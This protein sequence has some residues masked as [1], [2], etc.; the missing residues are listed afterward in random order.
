MAYVPSKIQQ[1]IEN[2]YEFRF[3]DYISRGFD[4]MNRNTGLFIGYFLVYIL[5]TV[6]LAAIPILGSLATV[7]IAPALSI[8]IMI[9]AH[10]T[11]IGESLQFNDFF[12][13]FDKLGNLFLTN[14]LSGL[15]AFA[16]ALPGIILIISIG[17][18]SF[19]EFDGA[20]AIISNPMLWLG[21]L[22]AFI[23]A[24]YLSISYVYAP[25]L[26]WFY[27]M[28]AWP[29]MEASRKLVKKQWGTTFGFIFVLGL[30]AMAGLILLVVGIIYT[31]PAVQCATYAA[32]ADITR[33]HDDDEA[34]QTDLID[35][36]VPRGQ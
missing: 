32:F 2:G 10:K 28:E 23:P 36:F 17:I 8:G 24:I 6:V 15:I 33:L 31:V 26:V 14:L 20:A 27:N 34:T 3:G 11:D 13:G 35:H 25:M 18:S 22:V 1:T 30:I 19:N 16:A 9:A 12:K 7:I 21:F 29:A 5:I 4:I